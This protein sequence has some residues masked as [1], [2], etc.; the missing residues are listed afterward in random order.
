MSATVVDSVQRSVAAMLAAVF[1]LIAILLWISS[2]GKFI[3]LDNVVHDRAQIVE[4]WSRFRRLGDTCAIVMTGPVELLGEPIVAEPQID[5]A[6][7][8]NLGS[9]A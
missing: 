2:R 6:W 5:E 4:P 8:G 9:F 1:L 3:Y 7:S